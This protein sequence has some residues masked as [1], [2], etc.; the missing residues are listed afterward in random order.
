MKRK[1][2][3]YEKLDNTI[4][5]IYLKDI[6]EHCTQQHNF[7]KCSW[8]CIH[9]DQVQGCNK[10]HKLLSISEVLFE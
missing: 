2:V 7:F 4:H 3:E 5:H 10:K 9:I 6:V 8:P 1:L